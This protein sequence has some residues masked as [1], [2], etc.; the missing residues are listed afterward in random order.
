MDSDKI[1]V[2]DG[3]VKYV[4][5]PLDAPV[6]VVVQCIQSP[7]YRGESYNAPHGVAISEMSGHGIICELKSL[8]VRPLDSS[9]ISRYIDRYTRR[10]YFV[11]FS[12][13]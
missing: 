7:T 2:V 9:Q 13:A 11:R 12:L 3:N 8:T 4:M 1:W 5:V 6:G 10:L